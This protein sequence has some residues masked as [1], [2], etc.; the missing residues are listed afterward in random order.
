V[1][2]H[3]RWQD[4][5]SLQQNTHPSQHDQAALSRGY[6]ISH[7]HGTFSETPS[8]WQENETPPHLQ[9]SYGRPRFETMQANIP[10]HPNFPDTDARHAPSIQS[11]SQEEGSSSVRANSGKKTRKRKYTEAEKEFAREVLQ[12]KG[13]RS[14][15]DLTDRSIKV[16]SVAVA[17]SLTRRQRE[18]V[19]SKDTSAKDSLMWHFLLRVSEIKESFDAWTRR[20]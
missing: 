4:S 12:R 16:M 2:H 15:K 13:A 1:Q 3:E 17:A 11:A 9:Q 7:S 19:A 14:G 10:P 8:H 6:R 20:D 5:S 18:I